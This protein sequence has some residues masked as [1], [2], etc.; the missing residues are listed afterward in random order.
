MSTSTPLRSSRA[1]PRL[2]PRRVLRALRTRLQRLVGCPDPYSFRPAPSIRSQ[3]MTF[4]F[5][6]RELVVTA[7]FDTPLYET[8]A[9]VV[10]YDC[11]RLRDIVPDLHDTT[12]LDVGA[13]V[14]VTTLCLAAIPRSTVRAFEPVRRNCDFLQQPVSQRCLER[15]RRRSCRRRRKPARLHSRCPPAKASAAD[16]TMAAPEASGAPARP[17]PPSTSRPLS[18]AS[19]GTSG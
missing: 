2:S 14:G 6:E 16:S 3:Q 11:Y 5:L 9:E 15:Q 18:P 7:G 10:D 17:W 8:I 1:R 19:R 13:N 4:R 12:I